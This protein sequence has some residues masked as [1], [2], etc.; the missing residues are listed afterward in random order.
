MVHEGCKTQV[1]RVGGIC[2]KHRLE[3]MFAQLIVVR[4]CQYITSGE[5]IQGGKYVGGS[6]EG[7]WVAATSCA[8]VLYRKET[9]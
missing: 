9:L 8:C 2:D 7:T 4:A 5:V 1:N 3:R 6:Y